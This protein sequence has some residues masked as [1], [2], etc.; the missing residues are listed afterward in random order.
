ML[1][2]DLRQPELLAV[3]RMDRKNKEHFTFSGNRMDSFCTLKLKQFL[4]PCSWTLLDRN[5]Y[6]TVEFLLR[7]HAP[8][9]SGKEHLTSCPDIYWP[10]FIQ[11]SGHQLCR[12]GK[13]LWNL[14]TTVEKHGW[15]WHL[16]YTNPAFC[17]H[18]V[19]MWHSDYFQSKVRALGSLARPLWEPQISHF[20]TFLLARTQHCHFVDWGFVIPEVLIWSKFHH[21]LM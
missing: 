4:L 2:L 9:C 12:N 20:L 21:L 8:F 7:R 5:S 10:K 18:S 3:R 15:A 1:R 6:W 19:L 17:P 11:T 14:S 16:R 13:A